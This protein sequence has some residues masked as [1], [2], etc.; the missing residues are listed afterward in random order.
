MKSVFS[1]H[2]KVE[3]G[4]AERI[5]ALL[6]GLPRQEARVAQ[7]MLLNLDDLVFQTGVSIAGKAGTSQVTVSRVLRRLGFDRR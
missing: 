3:H 6:A 5:Q 7:Y 1:S 4:V 2:P